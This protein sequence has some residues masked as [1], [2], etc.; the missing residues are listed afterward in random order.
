MDKA[1]LLRIA[2]AL[3]AA[4]IATLI[5]QGVVDP[6]LWGAIAAGLGGYALP[7]PGTQVKP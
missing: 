4:V 1:K 6:A 5:Q 3:A 7:S 2:L